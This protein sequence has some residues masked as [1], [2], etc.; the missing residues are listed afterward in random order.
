MIFRDSWKQSKVQR[1]QYLLE[2]TEDEESL[3]GKFE[4]P[5]F[6][7]FQNWVIQVARVSVLI[8]S[9]IWSLCPTY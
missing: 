4:H 2:P 7:G 5:L 6:G 8:H 9:A 3:Y 1:L